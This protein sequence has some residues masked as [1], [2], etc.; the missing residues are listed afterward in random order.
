MSKA[1]WTGT[2]ILGE[3]LETWREATDGTKIILVNMYG[4]T[5]KLP[6]NKV[7]DLGDGTI[8]VANDLLRGRGEILRAKEK[9]T[10]EKV[11]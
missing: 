4:E 5:I 8:R 7:E 1:N 3:I 6:E 9:Y 2:R 10:K 11:K